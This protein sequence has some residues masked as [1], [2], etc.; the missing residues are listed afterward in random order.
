MIYTIKKH[1]YS[2]QISDIGA[3]L[4]S[5]KD[6]A[7]QEE[8]IWQRD[9]QYWTGSAPILF[10]I[11]GSLKDGIYVY[12]GKTYP[13]LIH[14]FAK[15]SHFSLI[16]DREDEKIF[17]LQADQTTKQC[18]PFEFELEVGFKVEE[19]IL[20]VVYTVTNTGNDIMYF[21]FGSHPAFSLPLDDCSLADYYVEFE[22]NETL[23]RY[24]LEGGLLNNTS[25]PYLKNERKIYLSE[26]IFNE[27]ALIFKNILS[28]KLS[29][30]NS[31]T[32]HRVSFDTGGAPHLGIW[33]KPGASYVCLEPWYSYADDVDTTQDFT[34]KKGIMEL[35]TGATFKTGYTIET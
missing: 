9:P 22:K 35:S 29:I 33:S 7:T 20:Q 31:K 19:K 28:R 26:A 10:P 8:Y 15:N 13:L 21:T 3:E 4:Y 12:K 14:G 5:F 32:G 30:K 1:Q 25:V 2:A 11:V 27:D 18:Y 6:E 16:D 24:L 34:Q 23:D 17:I